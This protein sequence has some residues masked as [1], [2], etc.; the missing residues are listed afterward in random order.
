[1]VV[2]GD[3]T[4]NGSVDVSSLIL[5]KQWMDQIGI[6]YLA[7]PGNHDTGANRWR[8]ER[9][10]NSEYYEDVAYEETN[11]AKVF[12][13]PAILQREFDECVVIAFS[14]RE[15]DP[16]HVL[17]P[18]EKFIQDTV[19]PVLLFGHYPV[20]E[21]RDEGHLYASG[22]KDFIP[23]SA[24]DLKGI[25]ERNPH[26]RI[27]G[28]GHIHANTIR[29]LGTSCLQI[30]AGGLGP[31]ASTYRLY[32]ISQH[33]LH[34]QTL[35]GSGAL[36]YLSGQQIGSYDTFEYHLGSAEERYGTIRLKDEA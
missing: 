27:Y 25:I 30:T 12:Q 2:T 14:V 13:E 5:A 8:S 26:V 36:H 10:P 6:P 19:K 1:M 34:Y 29:K 21:T 33:E 32:S 24:V 15:H 4:S 31:G 35:L 11:F 28:C 23:A 16:D 17:A 22:H 7:I 18:L 3:L 9:F 20:I